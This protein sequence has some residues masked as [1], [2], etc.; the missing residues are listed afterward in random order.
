MLLSCSK[1]EF[2]NL[3]TFIETHYCCLEMPDRDDIPG[4]DFLAFIIFPFDFYEYNQV[5]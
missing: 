5:R 2:L 3:E 4:D 1:K